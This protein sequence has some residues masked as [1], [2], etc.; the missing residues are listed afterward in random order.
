M[1]NLVIILFISICFTL[2]TVFVSGELVETREELKE[3][4]IGFP[5]SFVKQDHSNF[6]PP[7]PRYQ[8]FVWE[9]NSTFEILPFIYS[10]IFYFVIIYFIFFT[11]SKMNKRN[12]NK[13]K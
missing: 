7:L 1:K 2:I 3:V 5:L 13:T 9:A 10:V 4:D 8:D 6:S 12:V 11:V